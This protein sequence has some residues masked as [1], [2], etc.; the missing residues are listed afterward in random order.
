MLISAVQQSD[1]YIYILFHIL[2]HY[3]LSQDIE[4]SSLCYTVGP[5]CLLVLFFIV[6]T[7]QTFCLFQSI[8]KRKEEYPPT[9]GF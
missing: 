2:F 5:S 1:C 8:P 3:G 4:C 7:S 6:S 9:I